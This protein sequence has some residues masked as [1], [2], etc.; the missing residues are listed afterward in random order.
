MC[1]GKNPHIHSTCGMLTK[2]RIIPTPCF[3][4]PL[5]FSIFVT[6]RTTRIAI[7]IPMVLLGRIGPEGLP[8]AAPSQIHSTGPTFSTPLASVH[9]SI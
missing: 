1:K 9:V 5:S 3:P 8:W 4:T 7:S 2:S 6:R